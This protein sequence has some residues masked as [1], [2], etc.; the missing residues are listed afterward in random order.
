MCRVDLG[1]DG[2]VAQAVHAE[3]GPHGV[4][5]ALAADPATG[6]GHRGHQLLQTHG[7]DVAQPRG[8]HGAD[9]GCHRATVEAGGDDADVAL[10]V[11]GVGTLD[12]DRLLVESSKTSDTVRSTRSPL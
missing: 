7:E 11:E 6:F 9:R 8:G 10:G 12:D 2:A 1:D 3:G 5:E 4:V